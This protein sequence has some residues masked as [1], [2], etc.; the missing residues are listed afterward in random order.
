MFRYCGQVLGSN[1]LICTLIQCNGVSVRALQE[2]L[3]G[4][5]V[6]ACHIGS[7]NDGIV[8]IVLICMH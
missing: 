6:D 5:E 3:T 2:T 1:H 8:E 4:A 7:K